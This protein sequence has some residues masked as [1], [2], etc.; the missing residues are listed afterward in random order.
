MGIMDDNLDGKLEQAELRG[1][2]GDGIKK[3][4]AVLDKNKD[5]VLDKSELAAASQMVMKMMREKPASVAPDKT[6][7][8]SPKPIVSARN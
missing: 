5:G 4:W 1:K 3:Y 6:V 7:A 8:A 2:I